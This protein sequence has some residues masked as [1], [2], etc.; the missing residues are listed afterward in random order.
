MSRRTALGA[1]P[2]GRRDPDLSQ[3]PAAPPDHYALADMTSVNNCIPKV[4]VRH[5]WADDEP[6]GS[7][8]QLFDKRANDV[9]LQRNSSQ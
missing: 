5:T 9:A 1:V 4:R 6:H 3:I 8:V 2:R 7:A